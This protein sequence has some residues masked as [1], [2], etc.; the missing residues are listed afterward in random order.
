M[1]P[2]GCD[3]G[4]SLATHVSSIAVCF[5]AWVLHCRG[6]LLLCGTAGSC[7][8]APC[9]GEA[10]N[11]CFQER[12]E[13][14][15]WVALARLGSSLCSS[16]FLH[17]IVLMLL[18]CFVL[19]PGGEAKSCMPG[20]GACT[21][22]CVYTHVLAQHLLRCAGGCSV[23]SCAVLCLRLGCRFYNC[24]GVLLPLFI[25][26]DIRNEPHAFIEQ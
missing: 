16:A 2:T 8:A 7:T 10:L 14:V 6:S 9:I 20:W 4:V 25:T 24:P 23:L 5:A 11:L 22:V 13:G 17:V 26:F 21:R 15:G 1:L 3:F 19:I 18:S 12:C